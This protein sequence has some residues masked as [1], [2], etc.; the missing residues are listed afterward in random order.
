MTG[1]LHIRD[2]LSAGSLDAVTSERD[3]RDRLC[4]VLA[5]EPYRHKCTPEV[6]YVTGVG[7][8][9][10]LDILVE[11]NPLWQHRDKF[12]VVGLELKVPRHLGDLVDAIEQVGRY[13]TAIKN[14]TYRKNGE[15]YP[16]PSI[17]LV[18]TPDSWN[19][20]HVY[21]WRHPSFEH[22][23]I[24]QLQ[25]LWVGVTDLYERV[26]MK[27]GASILRRGTAGVPGF[28]SNIGGAH[29]AIH[30]HDFDSEP[31]EESFVEEGGL[32]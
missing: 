23:G 2:I 7:E 22:Q 27:H 12:P 16:A 1:P 31:E 13:D 8:R 24:E 30:W 20:G 6:S 10:R 29:G 14:A 3:F 5:S 11:T 25:A 26:L 17:I 15:P 21:P 9:G 18:A 4:L 32:W 28:F 19:L